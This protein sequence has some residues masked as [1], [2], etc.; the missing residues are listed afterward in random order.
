MKLVNSVKIVSLKLVDFYKVSGSL[1]GSSF[2]FFEYVFCD[3]NYDY[4]DDSWRED[5]DFFYKE[6]WN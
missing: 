3:Y 5:R 1:N 6:S 4:G 2:S